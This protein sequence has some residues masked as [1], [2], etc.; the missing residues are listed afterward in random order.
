MQCADDV[1]IHV[2]VGR[3]LADVKLRINLLESQLRLQYR[4]RGKHPRC[5]QQAR[6]FLSPHC[7]H[8]PRYLS[9]V[10]YWPPLFP[11]S[12]PRALTMPLRQQND[13]SGYKI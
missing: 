4:D 1:V 8:V 11:S 7:S 2:R 5:H 10:R 3:N 13:N 12:L 9:T 6:S